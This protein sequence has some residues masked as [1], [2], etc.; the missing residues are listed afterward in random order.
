MLTLI[1]LFVSSMSHASKLPAQSHRLVFQALAADHGDCIVLS[2]GDQAGHYRLVVDAGAEGAAA[3]LQSVLDAAPDVVCELFVVSHV[4]DDHIGGVLALLEDKNLAGRFQDVWF[5]GRQHLEPPGSESLGFKQG[6]QLQEALTALGI[7]WNKAFDGG[8]VRMDDAG[9]PVRKVLPSGAVVTVLSPVVRDLT[10]LRTQWDRYLR[11]KA[12]AERQVQQKP[13]PAPPGLESMGGAAFDIPAMAATK[14]PLDGSVKNASSI[15]LLFE[16]GGKRVL[17][18]ADAHST[19][20][21]ASSQHLDATDRTSLDV[22]KLP[23]HG[24]AKNVTE[25]LMKTLS[26]SRYVVST[27]GT[28]HDHPDDVAIARVV[29]SNPSAQLFFNY[30]GPAS[31][32]W[33]QQAGL[34]SRRFTVVAGQNED[35]IRIELL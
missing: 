35:G 33:E 6:I 13:G 15:A 17:L 21:V 19:V 24:S 34:P 1:N 27:N 4:D 28:H 23:H 2:Y 7:S 14:T 20:L 5:N 22:F 26:G 30:A 29:N 32:R 9:S 25:R 18:G 3:R 8:A 11:R 31:E 10:R 12:E 16:Y